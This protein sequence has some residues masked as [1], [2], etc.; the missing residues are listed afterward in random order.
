MMVVDT[1]KKLKSFSKALS[2]IASFITFKETIYSALTNKVAM[3]DCFLEDYKTALPAT[4][5][6]KSSMKH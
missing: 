5:N 2:Q 4:L 3:V 6:T 1:C